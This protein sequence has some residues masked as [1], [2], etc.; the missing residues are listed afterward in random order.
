[1]HINRLSINKYWGPG[2]ID[3]A[4]RPTLPMATPLA[5][6]VAGCWPRMLEIIPA[7]A[8]LF[9]LFVFLNQS[10]ARRKCEKNPLNTG[11]NLLASRPANRYAAPTDTGANTPTYASIPPV[12]QVRGRA[13]GATVA[14]T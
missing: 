13:A 12:H 2:G 10:D 11:P 1:M 4:V 8:L 5:S 7:S 9:F 14:C 6:S 3:V